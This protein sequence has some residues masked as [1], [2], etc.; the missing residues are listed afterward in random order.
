VSCFV[1]LW[2]LVLFFSLFCVG[3]D[4]AWLARD[5]ILT[6][7]LVSVRKKAEV[8]ISNFCTTTLISQTCL[9][10]SNESQVLWRT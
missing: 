5:A 9:F 7:R 1:D 10:N 6:E 3:L 8:K 4:R 2:S